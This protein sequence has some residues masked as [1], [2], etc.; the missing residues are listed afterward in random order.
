MTAAALLGD[1]VEA[2]G[3]PLFMELQAERLAAA[4]AA[5]TVVRRIF[6]MTMDFPFGRQDRRRGGNHTAGH[7]VPSAPK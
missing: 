6:R 5:T 7:A 2:L 3:D 4:I 1:G